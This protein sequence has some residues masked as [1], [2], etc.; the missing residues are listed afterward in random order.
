MGYFYLYAPH[1]TGSGAANCG[2]RLRKLAYES[3]SDCFGSVAA[4]S[5]L[6]VPAG[7]LGLAGNG[8]VPP[9]LG[10]LGVRMG[11]L[12]LREARGPQK[13]TWGGGAG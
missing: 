1:C 6:L 10:C 9:R 13:D 5:W 2:S 7:R 11:T 12:K 3:P 4:A 8:R